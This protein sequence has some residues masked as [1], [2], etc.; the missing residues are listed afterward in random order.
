MAVAADVSFLQPTNSNIISYAMQGRSYDTPVPDFRVTADI[1]WN[2]LW[3]GMNLLLSDS[4]IGLMSNQTA[5]DYMKVCNC[6]QT[7]NSLLIHFEVTQPVST[8]LCPS[9]LTHAWRASCRL[10]RQT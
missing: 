9:A 6:L 10:S 3:Q 5:L 8:S 1:T 2:N 4:C 7:R